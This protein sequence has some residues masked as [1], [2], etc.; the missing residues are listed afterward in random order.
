MNGNGTYRWP[1]GRVFE[2]D[3]LSDKKHVKQYFIDERDLA[4]ILGLT[5]VIMKENGLTGS[6]AAKASTCSR[7]G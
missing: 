3:F 4:N 6:R 2:G 1:D 7:M 5:A